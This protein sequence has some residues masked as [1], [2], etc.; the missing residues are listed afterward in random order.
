MNEKRNITL[1]APYGSMKHNALITKVSGKATAPA[2][3]F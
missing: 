1:L 2:A 3:K